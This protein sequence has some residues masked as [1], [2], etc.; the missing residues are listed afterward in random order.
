MATNGWAGVRSLP[1]LLRRVMPG[2]AP[3]P[4]VLFGYFQAVLNGNNRSLEVITD[5]GEKLGGDYL[6][7]VNYTR[8]AYQ[9]LYEAISGSIR[10]F[11]L[12]TDDRYPELARSL[13]RIDTLVQRMLASR[14]PESGPLVVP[15]G[16][17]TWEM[18]EAVGGKNSNL[19]EIGNALRLRIPESFAVTT[20]AFDA[21]IAH[22]RLGERLERLSA[23]G[24][25]AKAA[26]DLRAAVLAAEIPH[27]WLLILSGQ[28]PAFASG[29]GM[30]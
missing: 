14:G 28:Q 24:L 27:P 29:Q 5:M 9:Q 22:N 19:A 7:D 12:L 30:R 21:F 6:F 3:D 20:A 26:A 4:K 17:L 25:D 1:T 16:D 10:N 23:A 18:A 13:A 2:S 11:T 8:S 15:Y